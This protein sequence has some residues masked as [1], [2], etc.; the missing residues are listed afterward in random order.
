MIDPVVLG[1]LAP[2]LAAALGITVADRRRRPPR[3]TRSRVLTS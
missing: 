2:L 1:E 3:I